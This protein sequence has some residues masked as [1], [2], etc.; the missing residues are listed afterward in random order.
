M[1]PITAAALT[2]LA[3]TVAGEAGHQAW[4]AL[5]TLVRRPFSRGTS[6]GQEEPAGLSSG[7]PERAALETLPADPGRAQALATA[8]G[9][10]AALDPEFR[11]LLDEW[12]TRTSAKSA[13][14]VHNTVSG[15]TRSGTIVQARDIS[16]LT[17]NMPGRSST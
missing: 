2:A 14:S 17:F 6:Q 13:G 11:V 5:T 15:G 10:R 1:D 3:G 12:W 9:V 4:Q 8:L 16:N 7:E